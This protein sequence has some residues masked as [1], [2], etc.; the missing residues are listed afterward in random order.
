MRVTPEKR[1]KRWLGGAPTMVGV[2]REVSQHLGVAQSSCLSAEQICSCHS[3]NHNGC[4]WARDA[5][6]AAAFCSAIRTG[7]G[8]GSR[9][10][11]IQLSLLGNI[12]VILWLTKSLLWMKSYKK[13]KSILFLVKSDLLSIC[14]RINVHWWNRMHGDSRYTG[15]FVW[16]IESKSHFFLSTMMCTA[17]VREQSVA[18]F[19]HKYFLIEGTG[20]YSK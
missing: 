2:H 16:L 15:T 17:V 4:Y 18:I 8:Y 11:V 12:F 3:H 7:D 13:K 10:N 6:S 9:C 5:T 19:Y 1:V 20:F 14:W